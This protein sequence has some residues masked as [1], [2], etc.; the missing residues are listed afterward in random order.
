MDR[1][2]DRDN[3]RLW[4]LIGTPPDTKPKRRRKS[5]KSIE[6]ELEFY[7]FKGGKTKSVRNRIARLEEA[8][9]L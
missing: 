4:K 3:E 9:E 8:L 1:N 5:K 2:M 7:Q 6:A